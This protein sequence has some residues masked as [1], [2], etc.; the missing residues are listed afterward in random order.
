MEIIKVA[1]V[2]ETYKPSTCDGT[3][4]CCVMYMPKHPKTKA[5]H[6]VVLNYISKV[7]EDLVKNVEIKEL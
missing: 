5:N 1:R 3:S 7:P 6:N 4:D 2:I